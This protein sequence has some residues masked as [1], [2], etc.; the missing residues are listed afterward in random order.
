MRKSF[1]LIGA[2]LLAC[3]V[4]GAR[5][6]IHVVTDRSSYIAGDLVYCS[7]FCVDDEGRQSG[8]SAVSYLEL[9]AAD[10]TV[11]EA[12]VALFNGRQAQ[13]LRP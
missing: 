2:S 1:F 7:L 4:A 6:R 13:R 3:L 5:E 9:I 8:F 11:A 10:G 12:K